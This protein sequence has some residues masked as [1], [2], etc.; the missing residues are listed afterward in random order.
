MKRWSATDRWS[1]DVYLTEER[2]HHIQERHEELVARLDLI[3]ETIRVGRRRQE[4]LDPARYRYRM[5]YAEL[6]PEFNHV[7]E[8]PPVPVSFF[9]RT[10]PLPLAA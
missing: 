10:M 9:E 4:P 3:L 1:N 8:R 2:W 5:A 6:L 7:S